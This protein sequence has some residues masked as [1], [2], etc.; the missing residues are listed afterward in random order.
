MT[1]PPEECL[2]FEGDL[3]TGAIKIPQRSLLDSACVKLDILYSSFQRTLID[4]LQ[5]WRYLSADSSELKHVN[6][7]C[8]REDRILFP[9]KQSKSSVLESSLQAA[10]DSRHLP[11]STLGLFAAGE[12]HKGVNLTHALLLESGSS[13][14]FD[15]L[16]TSIYGYC[17]DQGVEAATADAGNALASWAASGWD[18]RPWDQALDAARAGTLHEVPNSYLLPSAIY[19]PDHLHIVFGALERS[20]KDTGTWKSMGTQLHTLNNLFR[21]RSLLD[22]IVRTCI[23]D[24]AER[25]ICSARV[26]DLTDWKWEYTARFLLDIRDHLPILQRRFDR[27]K[28]MSGADTDPNTSKI[29]ARHFEDLSALL[30]DKALRPKC[31][32]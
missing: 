15:S 26:G 2:R 18:Q 21:K 14:R 12:I 11:L 7:F 31:E 28:V 29:D 8:I 24:P 13:L 16:R 3:R 5:G 22:R 32:V 25:R 4:K 30:E 27:V 6:F 10:Y 23:T 17:S 9:M 19:V 20:V 1:L